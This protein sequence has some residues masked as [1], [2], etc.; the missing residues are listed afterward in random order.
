IRRLD[1]FVAGGN[2]SGTYVIREVPAMGVEPPPASR[3]WYQLRL[4]GVGK[5]LRG[6][7]KRRPAARN[8]R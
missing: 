7:V 6:H 5:T 3:R 8:L 1:V 4:D 2:E